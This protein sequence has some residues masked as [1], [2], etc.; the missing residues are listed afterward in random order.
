MTRL[1]NWW[2]GWRWAVVFIASG[3]LISSSAIMVVNA[4]N[5]E[6]QN[7]VQRLFNHC[8]S[9]GQ[10]WVQI[11]NGVWACDMSTYWKSTMT[12]ITP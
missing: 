3:V 8:R 9:I 12:S 5:V 4:L 11:E 7:N 10:P 1:R 6:A 2:S